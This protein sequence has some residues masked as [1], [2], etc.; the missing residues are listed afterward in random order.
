MNKNFIKLLLLKIFLK[1]LKSWKRFYFDFS[2]FGEEKVILNI[3]QRISSKRHINPIYIDIGGYD[4]IE[5]SNTYKLYQKNW[6]GIIVEPNKKK[7][8]NWK[9]IRPNDYTIN[10]ALVENN[11]KE[12]KIKIYY[13]KKDTADETAYPIAKKENLNF[14]EANTI[15]LTEI[16]SLC[17][18]KFSKPFFL[19]IDIE[20]NESNLILELNKIDYKIPIICVEIYLPKNSENYSIFSFK[21]IK[22]VNFLEDNGYYLVNINGPS[23]IF[24]HKEFWVPYAKL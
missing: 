17:E 8:N 22:A 3:I 10:S 13:H 6:K 7:L 11:F 15:K 24:C 2:Q 14:Y 9:K 4:P 1:I 18:S 23:L 19:N 20:G 16:I 5:F 12:K 21:N